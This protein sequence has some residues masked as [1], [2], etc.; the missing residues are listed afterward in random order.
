MLS[1]KVLAELRRR[2]RNEQKKL[3]P[4]RL[5]HLLVD[6]KSSGFKPQ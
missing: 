6:S 1:K 2:I 5:T 4:T 3:N